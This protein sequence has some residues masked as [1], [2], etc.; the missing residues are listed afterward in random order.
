MHYVLVLAR[1]DVDSMRSNA[2]RA[3]VPQLQAEPLSGRVVTHFAY[4]HRRRF[5]LRVSGGKREVWTRRHRL[6]V[7][8]PESASH[9]LEE[10]VD[11]VNRRTGPLREDVKFA[12]V[13]RYRERYLLE[14]P[15]IA[16]HAYAHGVPSFDR[17]LRD[18]KV[19]ARHPVQ[20]VGKFVRSVFDGRR[21]IRR[22]YDSRSRAAAFR[23]DEI[24]RLCGMRRCTDDGSACE[25]RPY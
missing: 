21:R 3:V 15:Q 14:A 25:N 2:A 10:I 20:V 19:R 17:F 9:R 5:V 23:K 18:G 1:T 22:D 6:G 4:A 7:W 13:G 8:R 12:A 11:G 24:H 16:R